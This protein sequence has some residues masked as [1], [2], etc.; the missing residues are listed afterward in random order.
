M[1]G[2]DA[3]LDG[4]GLCPDSRILASKDAEAEPRGLRNA[5]ILLVSDDREQFCR[6]IAALRGDNAELGHMPTDR[7]R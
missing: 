3:P 2:M 7:I 4:Y 1:L 5:I 6:S